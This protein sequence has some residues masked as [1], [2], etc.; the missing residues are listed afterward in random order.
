[1]Q[2]VC[3]TVYMLDVEAGS[4]TAGSIMAVATSAHAIGTIHCLA[5]LMT[6]LLYTT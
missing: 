4:S 6:T 1:M 2:T 3:T 5:E